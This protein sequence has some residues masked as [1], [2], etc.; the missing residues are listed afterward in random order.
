MEYLNA[1]NSEVL[2]MR[3]EKINVPVLLISFFKK[4][5]ASAYIDCFIEKVQPRLIVTFIDNNPSFYSIS[6]R[7]PEIKTLFLQNG[8][9][10]Y[11]TDVFEILDRKGT[12][13]ESLKVD[14][15]MTF[16]KRIGAEYAR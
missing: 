3:G 8:I 11:H 15:M 12:K 2:Y 10:S 1:W 14:Y 4:E 5:R 13:K 7:H 16:G 9:R 6:D